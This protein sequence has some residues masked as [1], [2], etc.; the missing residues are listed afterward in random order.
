MLAIVYGCDKKPAYHSDSPL[1]MPALFSENIS[2][3]NG[4]SFSPEGDELYI[5]LQLVDTFANGRKAAGIFRYQFKGNNWEGPQGIPIA[6]LTDAYHPV[7][8]MDGNRLYFNSRSHPDSAD[9][10]LYHDL[11]FVQKS[12]DEWSEPILITNVNTEFYESY[13]SIA[14]NGNLYFNS[15]RPGGKGGMDFYMSEFKNGTYQKPIR[16]DIINSVDEENDLVVD[17]YE[18]F[19]IFNRYI[20]SDQSIDLWLST[21]ENNQWS[22]PK[23]LEMINEPDKWELTPSLSPD[24]KY[25]FFEQNSQIWQI[26]LA[27]LLK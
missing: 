27:P 10:Y 12:G 17:P 20:H 19:I 8:S 6:G 16:L 11:W 25:F 26:E 4:I 2:T 24:L 3:V 9:A 18:R 7:L 22:V 1:T 14:A 15:N 13:P 23:K 5:S 21:R